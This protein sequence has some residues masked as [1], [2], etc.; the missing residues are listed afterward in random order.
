MMLTSKQRAFLRGQ[1]NRI[2]PVFQ[3]G[4]GGVTEA[5]IDQINDAL[6]ARELV[7]GTV[8]N[9]CMLNAREVADELQV[10]CRAEVV[11]VIGNKLVLYRKNHKEPIYILP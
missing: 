3:V 11:Q 9:N 1:A 4:K 10:P 5:L 2:E 7:K 8:L 6:H